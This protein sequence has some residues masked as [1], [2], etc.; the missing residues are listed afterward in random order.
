[1]P[2]PKTILI[3]LLVCVGVAGCTP[4]H[5]KPIVQPPQPVTEAERQFE[6]YWEGALE[7]LRGN[8]YHFTVDL[9][10]RRR[11]LIRTEP[12][13]GKQ[14]FEFWRSDAASDFDLI[15][16]TLQTVYIVANVKIT[17]TQPDRPEYDLVVDVYR[18]RSDEIEARNPGS[19]GEYQS[20]K[21]HRGTGGDRTSEEQAGTKVLL[22][23]DDALSDRLF[24][25]IEGEA[26]Y[27]RGDYVRPAP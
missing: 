13:V 25:A 3:G 26:A 11:G 9:Q 19:P 21:E 20:Y 22:G 6:A 2:T 5:T 14:F 7:V 27:R 8:P 10:D 23:R 4:K 18:V 15:E 1:M 24:V 16:S 17:R 12:M